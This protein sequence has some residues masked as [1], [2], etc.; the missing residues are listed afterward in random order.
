MTCIA[1]DA[2][3]VNVST[4]TPALQEQAS[5]E[6]G[7]VYVHSGVLS[8][9][10]TLW[11]DMIQI[12]LVQAVSPGDSRTHMDSEESGRATDSSKRS[13]DRTIAS[14]IRDKIFTCVL[15]LY[16]CTMQHAACVPCCIC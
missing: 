2:W 16:F 14:R 6:L 11:A 9:A 8:V 10:Q 7:A 13:F 15:C 5:G 1:A 4:G 12:G 3:L